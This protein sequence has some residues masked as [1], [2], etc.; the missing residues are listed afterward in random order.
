MEKVGFYHIIIQLRGEIYC[1]NNFDNIIN[2]G[3][4]KS[5]VQSPEFTTLELRNLSKYVMEEHK[6]SEIKENRK[7]ILR[8]KNI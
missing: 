5:Y 4:N 1:N 6:K 3:A 2:P 7:S 8:I